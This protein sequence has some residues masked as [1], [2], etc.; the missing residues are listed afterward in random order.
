MSDYSTDF[1]KTFIATTTT[2]ANGLQSINAEMLSF[3]KSQ[4]DSRIEAMKAMLAAETVK[5]ALA[6]Q[7]EFMK[8]AVESYIEETSKLGELTT[9][10]AS[11]V[12]GGF[13]KPVA[14]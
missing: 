10:V 5:D 7:S 12:V 9:K 13:T 4:L 3:G 2:A 11:E 14:A 6:I 1:L 8:A